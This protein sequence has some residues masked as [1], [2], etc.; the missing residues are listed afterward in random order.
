MGA[1]RRVRTGFARVELAAIVVVV[2]V[3]VMLLCAGGARMRHQAMVTSDLGSL[4]EISALTAAY[5]ASNNE[6]AWGLSWRKGP[7][8]PTTYTDLKVA[9]DSDSQAAA[10]QAVDIIRRVG[11][12]T[13]VP[14]IENWFPHLY[15]NHLPLA[16]FAGIPLRGGI[17]VSAFEETVLKWAND[18][19]GFD[20]GAYR[21][22]QPDP[23]NVN[24]RWPFMTTFLPSFPMFDLGTDPAARIAHVPGNT[25]VISSEAKL[26][27]ARFTDIAYPSA[28]VQIH[29]RASRGLD[30]FIHAW[31]Q[32]SARIPLLLC[33]GSSDI[34]A[35]R[36]ANPGWNPAA[37]ESPAP[38]RI[39]VP[40]MATPCDSEQMF[41]AT[42][43][44][45][46]RYRFT[47]RD[48]RGRDFGG[49]EEP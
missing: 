34:R 21:P 12:A 24:T 41:P 6:M 13:H 32:D 39:G 27:Q 33:D 2:M 37:P 4:H 31:M 49:P 48:L 18:P 5:A 45:P 44:Y 19:E 9:T 16:E 10:C 47:R 22:C 29:A 20:R 1:Q 28:K 38:A 26:G 36:D 7:S 30:G 35:T 23:G 25:F 8:Q 14:R 11:G 43:E 40:S 17:W 15:Y 46:A 42:G 3:A